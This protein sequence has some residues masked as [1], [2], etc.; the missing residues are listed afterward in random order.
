VLRNIFGPV[1]LE[2]QSPTVHSIGLALNQRKLW[3]TKPGQALRSG[4]P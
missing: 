4:L 1:D 3:E 2:L